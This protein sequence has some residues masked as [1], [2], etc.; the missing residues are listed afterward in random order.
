MSYPRLKVG[1]SFYLKQDIINAE[2]N[3]YSDNPL[4]RVIVELHEVT[5][6]GGTQMFYAVR[7][8]TKEGGTALQL[9]NEAEIDYEYKPN[10]V[11]KD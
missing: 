10:I 7:G 9:H 2:N 6:S 5:C 8:Y 11:K 3:K 1:D 4:A